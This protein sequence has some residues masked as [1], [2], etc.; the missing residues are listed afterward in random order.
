M[1]SEKPIEKQFLAVR[2]VIVRG[3][4]ILIIR[5][6]SSYAGG[7]HQGKYDFPGGKVKPGEAVRD[8]LLRETR[9]EIGAGIT[10]GAPFF[11]DEWRPVIKG[12]RVQ[13]IGTFFRCELEGDTVTLGPDH[14]DFQW[15]GPEDYASLPLIEETR[16]AIEAHYASR[17]L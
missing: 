5:E 8:A 3:G 17:P 9:E 14:D 11:V 16:R 10:I 13:I 4:K 15:V 12:E 7:S 2:A 1:D 6:A